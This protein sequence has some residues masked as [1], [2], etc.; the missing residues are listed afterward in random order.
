MS[1]TALTLVQFGRPPI[2][3][4]ITEARRVTGIGRSRVY[5]LIKAGDI[6]TIK[7]GRIMLIPVA[8]IKVYL[9]AR[10]NSER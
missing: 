4:R 9:R 2:T 6:V 8:S 5:E 3:L 1:L 10:E 7:I